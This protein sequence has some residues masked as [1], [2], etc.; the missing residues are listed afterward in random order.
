MCGIAGL[1]F[2]SIEKPIDQEIYI[3]LQVSLRHRGP[4]GVGLQTDRKGG[5]VHTRLAIIDPKGGRQPFLKNGV[6]LVAN[7]EIYNDPS[8]RTQMKDTVFST[9]SDC[10]VALHLWLTDHVGY[11]EKLRGMY[12]IALQDSEQDCTILSRDPFGIKPLYYAKTSQGVVFA[13]EPQAILATDLVRKELN[14]AKRAELLQLQFTTGKETIYK[15]INRLL[16][17]E[18]LNIA[19]GH[20][21]QSVTKNLCSSFPSQRSFAN[22]TVALAEFDK[23]F[24]ETVRVHERADVPFGLF[25]SGGVDSTALLAMMHRIGH[26]NLQCWTARFA[27]STAADESHQAEKMAQSVQAQHHNLTIDAEMV[28]QHLPEIV[29]SMDDPAADYAIIPTWFLA[30]EAAR[31][32]KVILSGEGGD[33]LFAGYGRY[34]H[35]SLP[36]W[37]GGKA[38]RRKGIFDRTNILHDNMLKNWR[39][40]Y[41]VQEKSIKL[42]VETHLGHSDTLQAAQMLDMAEWVPNDLLLKLDRCLMHHGVEGRTPFLDQEMARFAFALPAQFKIRKGVGKWLLKYWLQKEMPHAQPFTPKQGF[43][44][45]IGEW[46]AQDAKRLSPL[47]A[48]QP[49]IKELANET[50]VYELFA[51]AKGRKEQHRAWVLMFYALWH[52]I[53]MDGCAANGSIFDVLQ[54]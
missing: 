13:S 52:K 4:D 9:G 51:Q 50:K 37:R 23:R 43:T 12:A 44:V 19:N 20:I 17:G 21:V 2:S 41:S 46:I 32:V 49:A 5:L 42:A 36:W 26:R 25:L 29:K 3:K 31:E 8:L 30:R 7:G 6:A 40:D 34:R 54:A 14:P 24:E 48:R 10:E 53:H 16:P 1:A 45:P 22:D 27:G 35:A 33:E 38:M 15:N 47:V 39:E 18:T 11:T 28:W